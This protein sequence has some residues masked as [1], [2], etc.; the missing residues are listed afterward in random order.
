MTIKKVKFPSQPVPNPKEM[1]EMSTSLSQQSKE[2]K[3]I[4]TL[5]KGKEVDNKM[6][7]PMKKTTQFVP[8]DSKDS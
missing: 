6:E 5:Q 7:M 3:A 1:H 8:L 4:M 2:V